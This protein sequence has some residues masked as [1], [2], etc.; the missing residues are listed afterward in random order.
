MSEQ[1]KKLEKLARVLGFYEQNLQILKGRLRAQN[2]VVAEKQA[3]VRRLVGKLETTQQA[4]TQSEP[5]ATGL[6]MVSHLMTTLEASV[7]Q[8]NQELDTSN[9]ELEIRRTELRQQMSKIESLEKI[10]TRT[11]AGIEHKRRQ[12]EQL[13]SDE[14]YLNTHF[15]GSIK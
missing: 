5:S 2:L 7:K 4:F 6:Q 10:V 15:T 3:E 13:Q 14:R 8:A 1:T 12:L 9:R 11:S